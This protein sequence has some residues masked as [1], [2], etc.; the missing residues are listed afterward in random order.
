MGA[1]AVGTGALTVKEA[2]KE[3]PDTKYIDGKI[4][5]NRPLRV[6]AGVA[7]TAALAG[8]AAYNAKA[9]NRRS[10]EGQWYPQRERD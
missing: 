4:L 8:G 5:R 2:L 7:A 6:D 9:N 3:K 10:Y 1:G